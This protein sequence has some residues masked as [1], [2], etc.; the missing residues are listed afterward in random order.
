MCLLEDKPRPNIEVFRCAWTENGQSLIDSKFWLTNISLLR[1]RRNEIA[2]VLCCCV[3]RGPRG[4]ET[5]SQSLANLF[6]KNP[7]RFL[8][9][10]DRSSAFEVTDYLPRH[11]LMR[12]KSSSIL[13]SMG[14]AGAETLLGEK[15]RLWTLSCENAIIL[16]LFRVPLCFSVSGSAQLHNPP[17]EDLRQSGRQSIRCF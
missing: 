7:S 1:V 11:Q 6:Y 13:W 15:R 2:H 3:T 8:R 5:T 16:K 14:A 17:L 9:P 12:K 10:R 4:A